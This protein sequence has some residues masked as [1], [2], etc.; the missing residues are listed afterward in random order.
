MDWAQIIV[1]LLIVCLVAFIV[2]AL[3]LIVTVLRISL[4]IRSLVRSAHTT[5][6]NVTHAI[7]EVG[8][9]AKAVTVLEALRKKVQLRKKK[10]DV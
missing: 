7:N 5:A 1:V 2:V 3:A 8:A 10:G 9:I 4:Q 6:D